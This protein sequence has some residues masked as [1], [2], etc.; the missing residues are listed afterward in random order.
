MRRCHVHKNPGSRGHHNLLFLKGSALVNKTIN[1][2]YVC[3]RQTD[4]VSHPFLLFIHQTGKLQGW[5]SRTH[6]F[7]S[8][9][10]CTH[11]TL[12]VSLH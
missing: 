8:M 11:A 7:I 5:A 6:I 3:V 9:H 12:F 4:V 10:A 1:S 2:V